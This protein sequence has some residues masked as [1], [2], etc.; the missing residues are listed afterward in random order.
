MLIFLYVYRKTS[1][2]GLS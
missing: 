1:W 2:S